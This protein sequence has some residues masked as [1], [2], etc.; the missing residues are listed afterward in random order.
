ML[1]PKQ[2]IRSLATSTA[3]RAELDLKMLTSPYLLYQYTFSQKDTTS[4]NDACAEFF[5]FLVCLSLGMLFCCICMELTSQPC[6][7][8]VTQV[9]REG[10]QN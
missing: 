9:E 2:S 10:V 6:E 8:N 5:F 3:V 1:L 4:T 7:L